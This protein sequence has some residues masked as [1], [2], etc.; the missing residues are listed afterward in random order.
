MQDQIIDGLKLYVMSKGNEDANA[1][2]VDAFFKE[3]FGFSNLI[4]L[5][6]TFLK[7]STYKSL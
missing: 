7:Q 6:K 2:F 3:I 1:H 4:F 5:I